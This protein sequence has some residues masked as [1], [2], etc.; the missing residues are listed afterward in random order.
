MV[1]HLAEIAPHAR[2]DI[3]IRC[4]RRGALELTI[5]LRQLVRGRDEEIGMALG[6]DRLCSP[7]VRGIAVGMQEQDGHRLY[8]AT[9]R[10][11]HRRP[12]RIL[13]ELDQHFPLRV[14]ALAELVAQI[15]LDQGLV[16]AKEQVVGFWPIDATDLV[17]IAKALRGEKRAGCTGALQDRVDRDG[18]AVE[19]KPRGAK[20]R[21][22]FGHSML[23]SGDEPRRRGQRFSE[24]K[25]PCR[26]VESGD[27]GEGTAHVGRQPNLTQ[28][29]RAQGLRAAGRRKQRYQPRPSAATPAISSA[30]LVAFARN[31]GI[32]SWA[33]RLIDR[34]VSSSVKSPKANWPTT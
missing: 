33:N 7:L 8:A 24:A 12:H 2:S 22:R 18:G 25:L 17:D 6:D 1:A 26:L 15:T 11:S 32:T 29:H 20:L 5:L 31:A 3:G 23:D 13:V 10:V 4:C 27:I 28:L 21:S 14:H 30:P 19:K 34:S 9:D 16:A